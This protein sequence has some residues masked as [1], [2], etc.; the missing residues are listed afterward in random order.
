[1]KHHSQTKN[2]RFQAKYACFTSRVKNG[3]WLGW[4]LNSIICCYT[5]R[6]GSLCSA[7]LP[8]VQKVHS[9]CAT[10]L[11]NDGVGV[12]Q[13]HKYGCQADDSVMV[14]CFG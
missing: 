10:A 7:Q 5:I 13:V 8:V 14:N 9:A 2:C 6:I 12:S 4:S 3:F 1:M 11:H